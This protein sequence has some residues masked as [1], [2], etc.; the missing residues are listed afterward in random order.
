VFKTG[1]EAAD[2]TYSL[3]IRKESGFGWRHDFQNLTLTSYFYKNIYRKLIYLYFYKSVF[4]DKS[5]YIEFVF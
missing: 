1:L 2:T 5:I 4:Q 3:Y